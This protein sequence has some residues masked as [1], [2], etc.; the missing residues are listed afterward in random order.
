M[1]TMSRWKLI[2][3]GI[4]LF[5]VQ[6]SAKAWWDAGHLVTAMIAYEN[7]TP[8]AKQRIDDYVAYIERDYPFINNF[9]AL[10]TWP[11]DLKAEGVYVYSSWHYTNIP[12]N[13]YNIALPTPPE[14]NVVWA[15]KEAQAIL[16]SDKARPIEQARQLSFL[17]HFVGDLHQ[18]LHSTSYYRQEMPGGDAGGN[19]FPIASFGKWRNL[20]ACW[21]DG[22]GYL[23][24][25]NN[26]NPYGSPKEP[27]TETEM[28]RLRLFA[29][30]I[31]TV[32]PK[33]E[34][35]EVVQ[36]DADFWALESHKLA[37][38]YGYKGV[39]AIDE[40][41]RK[42]YIQPNDPVS[43]YYLAEG[44]KVVERQLALGGY[45]LANILNNLF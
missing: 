41:G 42:T 15:I 5:M 19:S 30:N 36:L 43:D 12:Y 20:H 17:T 4:L 6:L 24:A 3:A 23:S 32:Y 35:P 29:Q 25:Y 39:L 16:Q 44:Q 14:V 11:D 7:L 2:F 26:I 27:I 34:L 21:D 28:E 33:E 10:S 40:N 13:P 31:M 9:V 38:Q 37:I 8:E 45:R 1:K 22:C 18:P